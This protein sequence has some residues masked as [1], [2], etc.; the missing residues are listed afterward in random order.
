MMSAAL[1]RDDVKKFDDVHIAAELW[2]S[3]SSPFPLDQDRSF[4]KL[5]ADEAASKNNA[6]KAALDEIVEHFPARWQIPGYLRDVS[7]NRRSLGIRSVVVKGNYMVSNNGDLPE[8]FT[9]D[10]RTD[11]I[12]EL[13][14]ADN[15]V[16]IS[17]SY[18]VSVDRDIS[19]PVRVEAR[20]RTVVPLRIYVG[21]KSEAIRTD[22]EETIWDKLEAGQTLAGILSTSLDGLQ[23]KVERGDARTIMVP[24]RIKVKDQEELKIQVLDVNNF[25]IKWKLI[26]ECKRDLTR[27][28]A[29]RA[30]EKWESY[31][32]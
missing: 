1:A 7:Y 12:L 2:G 18:T 10:S 29:K 25:R 15:N 13:V 30:A 20:D 16:K 27:E 6:C 31:R 22:A 26:E 5:F 24:F 11:G 9:P 19:M 4:F 28:E 8:Y 3:P 14:S 21:L 17:L 23:L 32:T